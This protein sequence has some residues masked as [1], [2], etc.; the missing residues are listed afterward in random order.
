MLAA[1]RVAVL[2]GIASTVGAQASWTPKPNAGPAQRDGAYLLH[3]PASQHMVLFSG[4]TSTDVF[5]IPNQDPAWSWDGANWTQLTATM[6]SG[7]TPE[8]LGG[9]C[10]DGSGGY[11][12]FG[13]YRTELWHILPAMTFADTWRVTLTGPTTAQFTLLSPTTRP[14]TRQGCGLVATPIGPVM[15]GGANVNFSYIMFD[16]WWWSGTD[17]VQFVTST[18]PPPRSFHSMVYDP[19]RGVV[20]VFG[21]GGG[22]LRNDTWEFDGDWHQ[23]FPAHSPPAR[24]CAGAFFSPVINCTIVTGGGDFGMTTNY[25]DV[26]AW[27]GTDWQQLATTSGPAARQGAAVGWDPVAQKALL[28]GGRSSATNYF[29]DTWE[30]AVSPWPHASYTPFGAG[31]AGPTGQVPQLAAAPNE[32]PAIGTTSHLVVGNLPIAL[33]LPIF[34]L[35]FSNTI[36]AN[37]GY[38]L[39]FDLTG[40]G[41]PGCEQRVSAD[42]LEAVPTLGGQADYA[43][44]WPMDL[45]LL[46]FTYHAQALVLYTPTG[47]AMSNALT[48]VVGL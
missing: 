39:P 26:W 20:V 10:P 28:F 29:A 31:C 45:S 14:F 4:R 18:T 32:V 35:G 47:G 25:A 36:D 42:V 8:G 2:C 1:I 9:A 34:V 40:F 24:W 43:I 5:H 22:A 30:V 27:D 37:G 48:G 19:V 16:T 41:W 23:R 7:L 46:G 3:D 11:L 33:T 38:A 13:G 12:V 21:G 17:W 44:T 6:P 15:F